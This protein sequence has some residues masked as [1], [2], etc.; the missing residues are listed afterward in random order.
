MKSSRRI[1]RPEDGDECGA[2]A[3]GMQSPSAGFL[4]CPALWAGSFT[5]A[6]HGQQLRGESPLQVLMV[7]TVSQGQG[8]PP[9]GGV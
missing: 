3:R 2:R 5:C 8:R 9:R 7:E 4:K 1:P 6:R